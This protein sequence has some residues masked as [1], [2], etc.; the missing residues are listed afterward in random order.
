MTIMVQP[1]DATD[2]PAMLGV[3]ELAFD[4]SFGE[5]W[6][7]P[8]LLGSL[9]V[10]GGWASLACRADDPVGFSLC[11]RIGDEAELLLIGVV[12]SARG[13]GMGVQLLET[14]IADALRLHVGIMF[15]EV[16]DGNTAAQALY[17]RC[18]FKDVGRRRDYYRGA[19]GERFDAVTM[20]RDLRQG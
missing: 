11:R 18:G 19:T 16:R 8:Q 12:P 20:R 13:I 7:G 15:L 6:S 4:P 10:A 14:A 5:A 17:R 2:V 1:A 3:I 9:V